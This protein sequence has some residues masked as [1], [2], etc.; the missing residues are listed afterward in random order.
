MGGE[1]ESSFSPRGGWK[2]GVGAGEKSDAASASA[3]NRWFV[4]REKRGEDEGGA[5]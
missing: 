5:I 4:K 1:E 3:K 2:R